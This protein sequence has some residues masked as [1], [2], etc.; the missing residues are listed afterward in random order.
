MTKEEEDSTSSE[1]II[2]EENNTNDGHATT[3]VNVS[4][5]IQELTTK[6]QQVLKS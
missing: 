1:E 3:N 4:E 5:D 6:A 2:Q